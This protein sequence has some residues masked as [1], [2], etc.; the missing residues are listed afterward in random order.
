MTALKEELTCVQAVAELNK[1]LGWKYASGPYIQRVR[2]GFLVSFVT[3]TAE[4]QKRSNYEYLD[5][6]VSFLVTP[7][8]TVFGGFWGA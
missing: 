4:E 8:G 1:L 6:Y 2:S 7:R 3:V 5:P